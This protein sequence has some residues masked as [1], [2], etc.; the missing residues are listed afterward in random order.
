MA[1][2]LVKNA[3][4]WINSFPTKHGVLWEYSS[5]YLLTGQTLMYSK[6]MQIEFGAYYQAHEDHANDMGT[7][8]IG[9]VCLGPTGNA[10]GSHWFLSLDTGVH[11][12]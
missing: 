6:H 1:V 11:I 4:F 12:T 2:H 5:R 10:Q 8:M 3:V 9:A 7:R